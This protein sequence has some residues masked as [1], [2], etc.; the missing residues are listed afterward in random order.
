MCGGKEK[1]AIAQNAGGHTHASRRV[2][3]GARFFFHTTTLMHMHGTQVGRR[4]GRF[5]ASCA[6]VHVF[7]EKA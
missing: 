4:Q 3:G 5:A 6:G 1:I 7:I 2:F